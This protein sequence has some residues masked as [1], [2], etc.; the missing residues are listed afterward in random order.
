M[1]DSYSDKLPETAADFSLLNRSVSVE[2]M[3]EARERRARIQEQ[4]IQTYHVP[5]ISFTLNIPGPVKILPGTPEFF[6]HGSESIRKALKEASVPII[7]ETQLTEHTGLE[8]FLCADAGPEVLKQITASL[9]EK[10]AGGRLYDID[11][12]RTD[13]S[14]VSREEIGLPGRRC[15]LCGAPAHACSRSRK[16]TVDELVSRIQQLIE[17]DLFLKRLFLAAREALTD[18]VSATPK[19]G[20]VDRLDN[21]AHQDMCYETFLNSAEAIAPYIR[22][23]AEQGLHFS[24]QMAHE[25]E[26]EQDLSL[27]FSQIRKTG[28]L[29]ETAM[30]DA[31]GGVNTHKGIIFSMGILAASAGF[32][33]G[34][35]RLFQ[36]DLKKSIQMP[37]LN[38]SF[39]L[40]QLLSLS[41][42]LCQKEI[43]EDFSALEQ[44][45]QQADKGV[46][47]G[48][49]HFSHGEKL[50]LACGCRGIRGE[51]SDG[52]PALSSVSMKAF[53][54]ALELLGAKTEISGDIW[55]RACLQTLLSLMAQVEDTNVI[56][57]GGMDAAAYVKEQACKALLEG[58]AV[59][60]GWRARLSA[61]NQ[62]FIEKNISPGGCADLL[63][64]TVF[65][66]RLQEISPEECF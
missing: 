33:F 50:Y 18:E 57:R 14:K 37:V 15:L 38:S 62:D 6:R 51:A 12:I 42:R 3:M 34:Q 39:N 7:F 55:N 60:S 47:T 24:R 64:L 53:S 49:V 45:R 36:P 13:G 61:M 2:D 25:D 65:L 66:L 56:H 16:H 58:G 59:K 40:S 28:L 44:L 35:G 26:K 11:I 54:S 46:G 5:V 29:A 20:L 41:R 8:L 63:A 52:F 9:E 32:L 19:P 23:M 31:T 4:L 27:L 22:T 30:F 43:L 10:T 1:N 48:N 17:E 21:G